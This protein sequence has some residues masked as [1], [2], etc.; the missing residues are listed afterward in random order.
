MTNSL[1][2]PSPDEEQMLVEVPYLQTQK[3]SV[4]PLGD[5][6]KEW[7]LPITTKTKIWDSEILPY[8]KQAWPQVII[9]EKGGKK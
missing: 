6:G 3:D 4:P 5:S 8:V 2:V 1:T 9:E 7:S